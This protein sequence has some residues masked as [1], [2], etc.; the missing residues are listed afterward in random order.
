[1][2]LPTTSIFKTFSPD[3][4]LRFV[5]MLTLSCTAGLCVVLAGCSSSDPKIQEITDPNSNATTPSNAVSFGNNGPILGDVS[6]GNNF[7]PLAPGRRYRL[8]RTSDQLTTDWQDLFVAAGLAE[9]DDQPN[10]SFA[11]GQ[12]VVGVYLGE[13]PQQANFKQHYSV[14]I[15]RSIDSVN[16]VLVSTIVEID[17]NEPADG[18][19]PSPWRLA[20]VSLANLDSVRFVDIIRFAPHI[21]CWEQLPDPAALIV[22]SPDVSTVH[23]N[24]V[25]EPSAEHT[26]QY[27]VGNA[28]LYISTD[29]NNTVRFD[30]LLPG[31][32]LSFGLYPQSDI[33]QRPGNEIIVNTDAPSDLFEGSI[34][35]DDFINYLRRLAGD[36]A[37][38]C[39][40]ATGDGNTEEGIPCQVAAFNAGK[41]FYSASSHQGI[42]SYSMSA[43]VSDE[44]GQIYFV[45][46]DS[47][48]GGGGQLDAGRISGFQCEAP[49]TDGMS[50][51]CASGRPVPSLAG[52]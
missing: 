9:T 13:Q 12:V 21:D 38:D 52:Q 46:F 19:N 15:Q 11:D 50:L 17:C 14:N 40:D 16:T 7:R 6:S 34:N 10:Y 28:A 20:Q 23:L 44:N 24:F 3:N 33:E 39:T 8:Y 42:D 5:K 37:Q 47:D 25:P 29:A 4:T 31:L 43:K 45:S 26:V 27:E 22:S 35:A 49:L 18:I 2:A 30:H 32:N 41:N 51:R 1:M 36:G 48:P